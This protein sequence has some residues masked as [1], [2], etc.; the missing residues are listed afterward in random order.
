MIEFT[1]GD[2]FAKPVDILVNPVNC[3]G[4][5]GA[6]LALAFKRRYHA[7][8]NAYR[9]ACAAGE[10]RPGRLHVW[11]SPWIINFPTK[12]H[13]RDPSRYEDIAAGLDALRDYLVPIGRVTVAL[14]ALGCGHGGLDWSRVR[15]LIQ[16]K[17]EDVPATILVYAPSEPS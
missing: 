9:Q 15:E 17:L 12:R 5:M 16:T 2:M 10:V 13:W 11:R 6:G 1:Q 7:M 14:P 3:V 8:F 4:V